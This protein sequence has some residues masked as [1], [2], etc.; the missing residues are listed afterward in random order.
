[1]DNQIKPIREEIQSLN[2]LIESHEN[3]LKEGVPI[4]FKFENPEADLKFSTTVT[5]TP[6]QTTP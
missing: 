5:L 4:T 1:L 3:K 2:K 6:P